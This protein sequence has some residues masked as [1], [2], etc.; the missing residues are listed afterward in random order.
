MLL[1][2][3]TRLG[4]YEILAPLGKGGMGHVYRAHD[5]RLGREVAVKVL[6]PEL[7]ADP[8]ALD[9]FRQ[10]ARA[11]AAFD[12]PGIV[13]V[14]SVEEAEGV[15]FITMQ[16]LEGRTL[17]QLI[18]ERGMAPSLLL[19][20]ALALADAL[21]AAHD[22]GIVHR[23]LKPSNVMVT[24]EGRVKVLDFGLARWSRPAAH[25]ALTSKA[26]TLTELSPGGLLGTMPYMSPEQVTGDEADPRSD[27]F[28][29][30]VTLYEMCCGDR[31]FYGRSQAELA[32]SILRDAPEPISN[33]R[34][35]LPLE[36][37]HLVNRC[38]EKDPRLR[39][40]SALELAGEL[41][42]LALPTERAGA[43]GPVPA[44]VASIAVLPFVN[45][46]RDEEDEYF[47]DGLADELLNMLA[48]I[49]G[50][51]VAARASSFHFRG[52]DSTIAEVGRTLKVA[53]VL[54]GSV[55]K[56]GDR[57]RIS[58]QLVKTSD[59]YP[60]WSETYDRMLDDI[61]A[62]QDDI[63]RSVVKEL[64]LTLLGEAADGESSG[65]V[66]AEVARAARGRGSDPEAHRLYLLARHLLERWTRTDTTRAIEHLE[67]ALEA[68]PGFASAWVEL[69]RALTYQAGQGW[70][71]V[72]EGYSRAREAVERALR[73]QPDLAEAHAAMESI[74]TYHDWDWS[75]AERSIRRAL[76]LA[77][78]M[79]EVLRRAGSQAGTQG[80][81]DESVEFFRRAILQDPL[82]SAAY[83][84]LARTC[85]SA[86]RL[87]EAE[88]ASR[89]S[90]ELAPHR[91]S[92]RALLALILVDQGRT[93]EALA[94]A[95]REPD[96]SWRLFGM[97]MALWASG[98]TTE[99]D[100]ALQ[101]YIARFAASD[102]VQIAE[103]HAVRGEADQAFAW[104][105]RAHAARDG[106]LS[107][108]M[109]SP[110]LRSL[111]GDARWGAFL[112][113]LGFRA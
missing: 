102:A 18:P 28:S 77:P 20:V 55:R 100:A 47:S 38:L 12:H 70:I 19:E 60:L 17:D 69:G 103:V 9:R 81:L 14:F 75:G 80:R 2:P 110:W 57:V 24:G 66:K 53:T 91:V 98:R 13:T 101:Q 92:T 25:V 4:A 85:H 33:R 94:E 8:R 16:L 22:R 105:E 88:D 3:G 40:E 99:S 113:K 90:L 5:P 43:F 36:L 86:G 63:A 45:R 78:G 73:L 23:D 52:K 41:R 35:D 104:L 65:E 32:S 84:G 95:A 30:G 96:E 48:K 44:K 29:L 49:R 27:V 62:V 97:A 10:E 31:P 6:S 79:V 74:Q 46:S 39:F 111:R 37:E 7:V 42:R 89:K 67:R 87:V 54:D 34:P 64:R 72:N 26:D 56:A 21:A 71:P 82:N 68:D 112:V 76:E 1:H 83:H 11:L 50:L 59:G 15:P 51:R 106:G 107:G 58:V 108:V 109:D 93:E 61:F